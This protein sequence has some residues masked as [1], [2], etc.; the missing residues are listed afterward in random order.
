MPLSRLAHRNLI[1]LLSLL[2]AVGAVH[3]Q[4]YGLT[5]RPDVEAYFDGIF[6]PEAPVIDSEWS[7]VLAFPNLVFDNP[8]GLTHVPGTN[9]L[10]V[11]EREGRIWVFDNDPATTTKTLVLDLSSQCQG[12]DDS[13]L[14]GLALHPDFET[15][16]Q[17]WIYYN[18]RGGTSGASGDLGPIIGNSTTRPPTGTPT[19]DRLSRFVLDASYQTTLGGE[20]VVIDQK[21]QSVWHNGGGMFFHPDN[22]FLYLTNGDDANP[23]LNT[24]RIDRA[25]FS[26]VIRIDVDQQGGAIS[27]APTKRP[28]NEVSPSWPRYYVPND[29]PFVG[30]PDALEEIYAIGLRSPH[31]MTVDAVTGRIFIGDVGAESREEISVIEPEDPAGLNFQWSRIEGDSGDLTA[32]YIGTNKRPVIDYSHSAGE[33]SCVVGGYVYRGSAFPELYGKYIFGDNMSGRIWYL[34]ES[35]TPATKVLL[36][37]LPDGP[38]PNSGNDYRGLGSFGLDADQE[39]YICRLSSTEGRI[40]KLERGGPDP[41]TPLPATLSSTGI[42]D[43][44]A[45]LTP[46]DR[47]VPYD[48]NTAFWS[49]HAVK[50]RFA[51]VPNGTTVG[52]T[53][54][55]EWDFPVGSVLVKHFEL[56]VD[57]TDPSVTR[58]LETRFLV[59]KP[60]GAVYGG[61]YKWRADQSDADLL[62]GS[63]TESVA[64]ATEPIGPLTGVD[65]GGP[66]LPGST[67][68]DGDL[69]TIEAGGTDI[70]GTTDEF[71]FAH[72]Q[73]TGDFDI[74]VRIE[75]VI[76]ADLY[77]KTG[78][79]V[80]E[81]LNADAK[82]VMALVFPSNAARNNNTGGY[83]FQYRATA[84]GNATALYP[85]QPQPL[86]AFP[87]TWLRLKREGDVFT[88][89]SSSDGHTWSE[90][91][92]TT[93]SFPPQVYFGLA[94]TAHTGAASTTAKFHVDS[95]RQPWYYPSRQDCTT[96]HNPQAGGVL[97]PDTRQFNRDLLYPGGTTDNQ[98][99]AWAHV[100]LFHDAPAE[101]SIPTLDKLADHDDG[102]ASL[103]H[104]ARSYFDANCS[105]CHRPGGVQ[106]LWDARFETPFPSQ[107]IYYGQVVNDLGN[108]DGRVV[109]PE[110]LEDSLLFHRVSITG[111]T[112]MPPLARNQI[113]TEGVEMLEAW[114]L[115]LPTETVLPPSGLVATALSNTEVALSWSD[116]SDN[117]TGFVIEH[118]IDG[119][120][121]ATVG[122]TGEGVTSF[123][124][125]GAEPFL[126]QYYR[127]RAVGVYVSS[128]DSNTASVTPDVG[129]PAPEIH[130]TGN[131]VLIQSGIFVTD[132]ANGTDFGSVN[133]PLGEVTHSFVIENIGNS[134]LALTGSPT[135]EIQGDDAAAFTVMN[136]PTIGL[137]GGE[138]HVFDIRFSPDTGGTKFAT[139][140]IGSDDPDEPLTVFGI[141]GT[142][143][144]PALVAWWRFDETSGTI[145]TDSTG[146][147]HDGVL[148]EP[149]PSWDPSGFDGGALRFTG[150]L[151]QSVTVAADPALNPTAGITISS[152]VRVLDWNG[153]RRVLQ[154]GNGD[155]QYRLLAEGGNLVWDIAGAG[156][157][158]VPLPA[159]NEWF[160]VAATYDLDH[161]RI[162]VDGALMGNVAATAAMPTT[163]DPIYLGTKTPGSIDGDHLNGWLD[164]TRLYN[165]ALDEVE[166]AELAGIGIDDGLLA[167]WPLDDG[168]GTTAADA[169][170]NGHTG[171]LTAP[172]P[173]W[174]PGGKFGGALT[175]DAQV[176]QSVSVP[177]APALN[178]R[179]GIT[180]S[181]WVNA[182]AWDGNNRILQKGAGDNQ[183]R[184]MAEFGNFAWDIAGVGRIETAQ[185]PAG[186]WVHVLGTYDGERM[187]LY[188][189]GTLVADIPAAGLIPVTGDSLVF[190]TKSQN[191]IVV[192]RLSGGLDEVRIYGRAL[193]IEEVALLSGQLGTLS[194]DATDALARKGTADTGLF[195][196]SRT[197]PTTQPLPVPLSL[198]FGP[199]QAEV[200]T[201]FTLT[202]GISGFT[203]PAGQS[204]AD[205]MVQGLDRQ[206][207]TGNL[208]VTLSM[209][210]VEGY[211]LGSDSAQVQLQDS[212]LNQWKIGAFGGIAAAQSGDAGD[213]SDADGDGLDTLLEAA[214][215][216]NPLIADPS[217]LPTGELQFVGG[218]IYLVSSYT[219]PKPALEGIGYH[220]ETNLDLGPL[221]QAAEWV[222][223]YPV[224]NLDGTETVRIRS[225]APITAEPQQFLRLRVTRP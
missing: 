202:P 80:R 195:T 204:S 34:D 160:H 67:T 222:E 118:S 31:R 199:G 223:G 196:V 13:G 155:N 23:G 22:G 57:D 178:P 224:D 225:L 99:R 33:G 120:N 109:V 140:L 219:R 198:V 70:W 59:Q 146:N 200:G 37:T 127:V 129:P 184:M 61:T 96:C 12:W 60:D 107:G 4:S 193:N 124:H 207:V 28:L 38:G 21:D 132:P 95:R 164:D 54:S 87:N 40:Y 93:L 144:Y 77:T 180:V 94:V 201:D 123:T 11:W 49:D 71:H 26:C 134:P 194:L 45:T 141:S 75:S 197:G 115:S 182:D 148:T 217:V 78:L 55:G 43:D 14:L 1:V 210:G 79:M 215:G 126:T 179:N 166:I 88:S 20:Y 192:N 149:L 218:Q 135:V 16:R 121:F 112:Q 92:S 191:S 188:Y 5:A 221:W 158:E 117:E 62:Y 9:K 162:Y 17:M 151:N 211:E 110:N 101:A 2:P 171:T 111:P 32:P 133:V 46:S 58:R 68:R 7:T 159:V 105:Y 103:D 212:P 175:F 89:F 186:Q 24:Q 113:D 83:E 29:N 173:T 157:I 153:N 150:V 100:G 91:A 3:A 168:S 86:V 130:I 147:G 85:P 174:T 65:V 187:K 177:D 76:Q 18:W 214:L 39:L 169:T 220:H 66:A 161:M 48:L 208:N 81:S 98:I 128:E 90:Y 64:I 74:A 137:N 27:H 116:G 181:A 35:T 19:R 56:P 72:Q 172:L 122:T 176:G 104:R 145:A 119:S 216:A 136:P 6:P 8:V 209:S 206:Q 183:Y 84:G 143:I 108:P 42:F 139:V 102:S 167:W 50:T 185:P 47:L 36:A 63:L 152:W 163:G 30:Q 114:I 125:T 156:R 25:L 69:I 138:S 131:G 203:I 52:F 82:H 205:L 51:A 41:G 53:E 44:L 213:G 10:I 170:G 189:D 73:R 97:G 154:K 15:N 190:A 165:R 142:G 106:A